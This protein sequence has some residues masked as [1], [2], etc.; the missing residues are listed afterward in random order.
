M[1]KDGYL[2]GMISFKQFGGGPLKC[3]DLQTGTVKWEQAGVGAGQVLLAGNCL[4]ALSDAGE[5][6]IVEPSP[7]GYKELA[8]FKALALPAAPMPFP[9]T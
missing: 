2:Y 4:V 9:L 3:V 1:Q 7:D 5:V 8:R 6:V